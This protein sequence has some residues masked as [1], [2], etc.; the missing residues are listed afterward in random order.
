M[1]FSQNKIYKIANIFRT[2]LAG[3]IENLAKEFPQFKQEIEE[4]NKIHHKYL[5]WGIKQLAKGHSK[6]DLLPTLSLFHN[7]NNKLPTNLRNIN[8]FKDLKELE[9][10]LKETELVSKRQEKTNIK[11]QL[12]KLY[13]DDEFLLGRPDSKEA[14]IQYGVGTK[15]CITMRGAPYYEQYSANNVIFYFLFNKTLDIKNPNYKIAFA[16]KRSPI[17]NNVVEIEI[18]DAKD[19]TIN[20]N[21][22]PNISKFKPIM[23]LDVAKQPPNAI[24]YLHKGLLSEGQF[25]YIWDLHNEEEKKH[26][27]K[28]VHGKY[29]HLL[30]ENL[31]SI[32]DIARNTGTPPEILAKLSNGDASVRYYVA[33]NPNTP[34]EILAKLSNDKDANVKWYVARNPNTPSEILAKLSNDQDVN[35][36]WSV[37]QNP[38]TPPEILAKLSNDKDANNRWYVAQNLNTPP[39][40][41]A[42]LSNDIN[43]MVRDSAIKTL[44]AL[45]AKSN[46]D[47]LSIPIPP[48]THIPSNISEYPVV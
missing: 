46:P 19:N 24:Y 12:A 16:Y 3:K 18:F 21:S 14:C 6:N 2:K 47:R 41:L 43:Q 32:E 13:E 38:N 40:I 17:D 20:I 23:D 39:E 26:L 30:P 33:Q 34:P 9:N 36:R 29:F 10:L 35:V 48:P 22:V 11:T 25:N 5:D 4:I 27:V 42:K 28:F 37:A 31:I 44:N 7:N 45:S 1:P 15:W 8:F